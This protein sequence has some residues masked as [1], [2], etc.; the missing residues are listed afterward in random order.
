MSGTGATGGRPEI[1][2]LRRIDEHRYAV[3]NAGQA[4]LRDV[5]FGGQLL[6]Q[7]IVAAADRHPGKNVRSVQAIFARA[8]RVSEAVEIAADPMHA[9]R[10]FASETFTVWQGDRLCA[11]MLVLLDADEPDVV[12]HAAPAPDVDGPEEA[13]PQGQGGLV[14]PGAELRIVGG[15][16]TWAVDAPVAPAELFLWMRGPG[17]PG[18]RCVDQAVVAFATDG[19][20]IGTA[21]RPHAG[22]GQDEAHRSLS[23]GVIAHT[24]VFHEPFDTG[25]WLLFAH[26]S[27]YAG[28]GRSFGEASVYTR[29]GRLVAS[30]VQTNMIRH[31]AEPGSAEGQYRTVM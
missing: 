4:E 8:A 14:F 31:F 20:L 29:D 5:V 3:P 24:L 25:E 6:A 9:G 17:S 2:R 10:A 11:R 30:F 15:V 7:V 12:R 23:T 21:M 18:E 22:I 26:H 1:L 19:F 27:P 13:V 28:G 16:D